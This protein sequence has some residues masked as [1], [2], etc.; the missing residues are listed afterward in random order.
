MKKSSRMKEMLLDKKI[1]VVPSAYDGLSARV[2]QHCGFEALHLTGAGS[3]A[4]L[5]GAADMG[6]ATI[7]EMST[8]A[9]NVVLAVDVPVIADVDTGFGNALN[10]YRS[11]QEYERAGIVGTH[12]EDQVTPKRCGHLDGKQLITVEE[13]V[14]KIEAAMAARTDPD[15]IL[16]ART[17]ARTGEGL[18]EAIRRANIYQEAGADCIFVES[19]KSADEMREIRKRVKGPLLANMVE[20]GKTPPIKTSDLEEMGY[21]IVIYPVTGWMGAAVTM[22]E[23]MMELRETGTTQGFW[24]R[25]NLKMSFKELF[26]I[27]GYQK[28]REIEER[29]I[30]Q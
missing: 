21:N 26:D 24:E 18:D 1:A 11:I 19:P 15:F 2:I 14:G 16:I 4:C 10:V 27:L 3:S 9:K 20:G 7:S 12:L 22:R 23:L 17:D 28:F 25:T 29:Y 6:V 5:L 13:M 30:R 8:H